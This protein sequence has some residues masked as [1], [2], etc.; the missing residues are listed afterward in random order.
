MCPLSLL[1]SYVHSCEE[2][3]QTSISYEMRE[4]GQID[5][6]GPFHR[7][8]SVSIYQPVLKYPAH[9]V[10]LAIVPSATEAHKN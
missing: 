2:L 8:N 5:S 9:P 1:S 10:P 4:I 3:L 6:H 7:C